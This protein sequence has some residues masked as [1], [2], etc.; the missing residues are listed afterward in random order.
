MAQSMP[1]WHKR[2]RMLTDLP[3]CL[4][5]PMHGKRCCLVSPFITG[6]PILTPSGGVGKAGRIQSFIGPREHAVPL[7]D[8]R[9]NLDTIRKNL[10]ALQSVEQSDDQQED[11]RQEDGNVDAGKDPV[12]SSPLDKDVRQCASCVDRKVVNLKQHPFLSPF[13]LAGSSQ[14]KG[15]NKFGARNAETRYKLVQV[16]R[17]SNKA[18]FEAELVTG[19]THQ[20]RIHLSESGFPI[21]GDPYYNPYFIDQLLNKH[22][23]QNDQ[24]DTKQQ[25][26]SSTD[27]N[28]G[29]L[30]LQAYHLEFIHPTTLEPLTIS[31][32]TPT[33]WD[34]QLTSTTK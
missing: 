16:D 28:G 4:G 26:S 8:Y 30:F 3:A 20:L 12:D 1:K 33:S 34:N 32:P 5:T 2:Y 29:E 25:P 9:G 17:Q 18:L 19:R 14:D 31:L 11:G 22:N 23:H 15:R 21:V 6:D 13:L 24:D 7:F 10:A 27:G